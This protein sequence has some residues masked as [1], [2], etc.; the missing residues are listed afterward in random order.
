MGPAEA[1]L[2]AP[3]GTSIDNA[4]DWTNFVNCD[5]TGYI[6]SRRSDS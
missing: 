5:W 4:T 3:T 1:I 2:A 6:S